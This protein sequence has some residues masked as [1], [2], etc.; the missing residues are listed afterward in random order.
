MLVKAI[1]R[2]RKEGI[3]FYQVLDKLHGLNGNNV[4]VVVDDS[5]K[6][7]HELREDCNLQYMCLPTVKTECSFADDTHFV[8]LE[9]KALEKLEEP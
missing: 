5:N 1:N 2:C 3:L 6:H 4:D 9:E 8:I 7:L